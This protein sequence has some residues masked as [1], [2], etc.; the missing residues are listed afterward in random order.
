VWDEVASESDVCLRARCPH[1]EQ[2]L[3][4]AGAPR[5]GAADILVVNHHL[6]FSDIAVRRLQATT[7]ARP[8]CRRTAR[9][10][11]D[12]AHNLEDAATSHLGVRVTRRGL[13]RCW[14]GW[15]GAA[16]ACCRTSS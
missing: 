4:P 14:A 12:E 6:L 7:A 2:V 10:V 11:L 1:F 13:H 16:G 8:C 15:S 3:L 5:G 9:G